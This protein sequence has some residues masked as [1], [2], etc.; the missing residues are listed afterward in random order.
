MGKT[1]LIVGAT[2][3]TGKHLTEILA[4]STLYSKLVIV[5]RNKT[6]Y[7]TKS[8]ISEIVCNFEFLEEALAETTNVDDVFCCI[9]ST[10]KK[11]G[12]KTNFYKIDCEY[13][14][15]LGRWAKKAN[16]KSFHVISYFGADT[17]SFNYYNKTKGYMEMGVVQLNLEKTVF[18][19]PSLLTG[20][21]NLRIGEAIGYV[22]LKLLSPLLIGSLRKFRPLRVEKLARAM[23]ETAQKPLKKINY[24][25]SVEL[26]NM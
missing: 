23:Y 21:N 9:G 26:Q 19:H 15:N 14:L 1:A 13:V 4:N 8:H 17:K 12:S 2:G 18:Y 10:L 20:R 16:V 22:A 6:V 25:G 24:I 5:H 11:A 3:A 7:L